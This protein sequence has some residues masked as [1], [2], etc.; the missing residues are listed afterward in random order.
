MTDVT[1]DA[2]RVLIERFLDAVWMETGLRP[3]TLSAYRSDLELFARWLAPFGQ[4]LAHADRARLLGYVSA[5]T[6]NGL[7]AR[8]MAR[9]LASLRRFY[10]YLLREKLIHSDP[11][12][13]IMLPKLGRALPTTLSEAQV[14]QILA[15]PDVRLARGLR[16]RAM[17]E[18]LYATGLRVSELVNLTRTQL[19]LEMGVVRVIGKGDKERLVPMGEDAIAWLRRY[20]TEARPQLL[21]ERVSEQVFVSARGAALT[22]QALWQN[23]K[24]YALQAG[25][26]KNLSPHTL[27]HAFA[28]HL[29]NHGADLRVV[30]M[31]LGHADLST[32]QIYT[33]VARERLQQLH[34]RHHPR[35]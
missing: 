31:L 26:E 29:V 1:T 14:E 25:I 27:R 8:S 21:R 9:A 2:D 18:T 23:I 33:Q 7:H 13:D 34:K 19:N 15:A 10:R 4:T 35:G 16:D 5:Q 28:T 20:L 30:Q 12:A 24:R 11:T 3:N 17:L 22:R 6:A 32:T